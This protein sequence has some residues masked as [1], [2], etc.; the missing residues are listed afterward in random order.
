MKL[1]PKCSSSPWP[2]VMVV[3]LA[4]IITFLTWLMLSFAQVKPITQLLGSVAVF[5]GVGVTLTHYV[6]TCLRRHCPQRHQ[7]QASPPDINHS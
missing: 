1:C 7:C 2:F 3:L 4:G 5:A 6:V